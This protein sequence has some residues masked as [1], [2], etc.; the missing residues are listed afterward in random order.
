MTRHEDKTRPQKTELLLKRL[1][2][3]R[4]RLRRTSYWSNLYAIDRKELFNASS[5]LHKRHNLLIPQANERHLSKEKYRMPWDITVSAASPEGPLLDW[6]TL[7]LTFWNRMR[8]ETKLD[9]GPKTPDEELGFTFIPRQEAPATARSTVL[10]FGPCDGRE[11]RKAFIRSQYRHVFI[12][13]GHHWQGRGA[14]RIFI[15]KQRRN[16][17]WCY[18]NPGRCCLG[19]ALIIVTPQV[20][21]SLFTG[22]DD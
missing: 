13:L 19:N 12:L 1:E 6:Y 11:Q 16:D 2:E 5:V 21:V 9:I 3:V 17:S 15:P 14:C 18:E 22:D 7:L 4:V 8:D 10:A 20:L